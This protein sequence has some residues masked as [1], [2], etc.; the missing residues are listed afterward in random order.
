MVLKLFSLRDVQIDH[1][2]KHGDIFSDSFAC[3]PQR[4][5]MAWCQTPFKKNQYLSTPGTAE[6]KSAVYKVEKNQ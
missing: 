4:F 6:K 2:F 5:I 1:S 3:V